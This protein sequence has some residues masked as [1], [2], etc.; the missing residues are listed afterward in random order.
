[1]IVDVGGGTTEVAV[2]SL[3][4]VVFSRSVRVAGDKMDDAIVAHIKRKHSLLIGPRTAELIKIRI[5]SAFP[6]DDLLTME[7]KGRDLVA[8]I[9]KT[10]EVNADEVREALAEP[11]NAIVEALRVSLERTPP[12][13]AADIVDR[14]IVLTGGGALLHG[15]DRLLCNETGLPVIVAED[16][17]TVVVLGGG[18]LLDNETLLR[19]VAIA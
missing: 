9:P 6:S 11:V 13:L 8:G 2:I 15:L 4:G 1:M 3:G 19:H 7:V 5:G 14:G 12:E 10:V 18:K 16:P 17:L